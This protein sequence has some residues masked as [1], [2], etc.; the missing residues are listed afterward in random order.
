[1]NIQIYENMIDISDNQQNIKLQAA[2]MIN[3]DEPIQF[4]KI[5]QNKEEQENENSKDEINS[6]Q[7]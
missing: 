5:N 4:N 3:D 6:I 7:I 1:M 2:E